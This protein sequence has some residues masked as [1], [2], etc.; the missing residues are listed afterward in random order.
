MT[1]LRVTTTKNNIAFLVEVRALRSIAVIQPVRIDEARVLDLLWQAPQDGFDLLDPRGSMLFIDLTVCVTPERNSCLPVSNAARV[2][3]QLGL[4]AKFVNRTL[5]ANSA[6]KLGVFI[7]G[8][9]WA[10]IS[11]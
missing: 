7:T 8:L 9:P 11:P 6:S 3:A 5:R 1:Y 10:A 2:G 4:T